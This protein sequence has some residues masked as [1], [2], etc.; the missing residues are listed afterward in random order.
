MDRAVAWYLILGG[1]LVLM[2][3]AGSVLKRLPLSNALLY[4][5]VGVG[6]GPAGL[7]FIALDP[8]EDA[9]LLERLTEVAVIVSLFSAG[10]KL[11]VPLTDKA[12]RLPLQLATV[13]MVLSVAGVAAA[14]V[15][16]LGLPLGVAV[17]LG[18]ILAPTDPV[19]A[20]DVQM[21]HPSDRDR[22]RFGLT[23]E[24][25]MNDGSAFP[26]VMLGLGLLGH[27]HLSFGEGGG[28]WR[29]ALL[30]VLWA[31]VGGVG[32]GALL[33]AAVGRLVLY[34]R[35]EHQQAH[36]L[37]EFLVLGLI[38]LA[39]G[40]AHVVK[41]YGFLAVFAAGLALRHI[42][43]RRGGEEAHGRLEDAVTQ[44]HASHKMATDPSLAPAF[45]ARALLGFNEQLERIGEV[46]VVVVVGSLLPV[47]LER[48]EALWFVPLL[49]LVIRPL[50]VALGSLGT[51]ATR[52]Q[53]LMCS[54]FGVRGI[55]SLYY[56]FYALSHG[57]AGNDARTLV[58]VTLLT[59]A[60]S[61]V[62]HGTSVTP[63]MAWYEK[64]GGAHKETRGEAMED[65][66]PP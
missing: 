60:C 16:G 41:G 31:T 21:A 57:V 9:K 52:T 48:L 64:Q 10:L 17:L 8:F 7:G 40:V 29:W 5:G 47:A 18:A 12:W 28:V 58:A 54:W 32:V 44:G 36:G 39:Y 63:L 59:I 42:E 22:L 62:L 35:K 34:L 2:A 37:D 24:A 56:L 46:L 43:V 19:L 51:D 6:L 20:S 30:D 1:L 33:G 65:P 13:A 11:R 14:G 4:L 61:A 27:H 26:F 53:R 38:A 66:A 49:L 55:G 15:W 23:G 25:G 50:S 45:M 3:L